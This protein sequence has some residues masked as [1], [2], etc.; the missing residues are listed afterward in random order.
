MKI[1]KGFILREFAGKWLAFSGDSF[2]EQKNVL[3]T[4]NRTGAFV[5]ELL[6]ND[7]AYDDVIAKLTERYD[8]DK[9]RAKADFEKFLKK[10]RAAGIIDE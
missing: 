6:Q 8:V 2:E 1:K 7:I 9:A 4:L 10:C 5:W 3:V